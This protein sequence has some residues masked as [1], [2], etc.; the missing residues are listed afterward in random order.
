MSAIEQLRAVL[1]TCDGPVTRAW[2]VSK[3]NELAPKPTKN[4]DLVASGDHTPNALVALDSGA[5]R[6]PAKPLGATEG[7]PA[8]SVP[9]APS[10]VELPIKAAAMLI[11]AT[12]KDLSRLLKET[13]TQG[14][15]PFCQ[16]FNTETVTDNVV[17]AIVAPI[18][19][20]LRLQ[21]KLGC[22]GADRVLKLYLL[23]PPAEPDVMNA[24]C[25]AIC[26]RARSKFDGDLNAWPT[27]HDPVQVARSLL[28]GVSGRRIHLFATV[29]T[30][31]WDCRIGD[32]NW[33]FKA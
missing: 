6:E 17:V 4:A 12:G 24:N 14:G 1:E 20:V 23:A 15:E 2:L 21:E 32:A 9:A 11:T 7:T 28:G 27:D 19:A 8:P 29:D 13:N 22:W 30:P 10:V 33:Q 18:S 3:C 16:S 25:I 26:G 31:G 5:R